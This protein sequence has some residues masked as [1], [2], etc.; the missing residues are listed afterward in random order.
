MAVAVI[1]LIIY[2]FRQGGSLMT[3]SH[4]CEDAVPG[5]EQPRFFAVCRNCRRC[6][7]ANLIRSSGFTLVELLVVVAIIAALSAIALPA[8]SKYVQTSRLTIAISGIRN[9]DTAIRA[10]QSENSALPAVLADVVKEIPIDPWGKAY[11][12]RPVAALDSALQ[13]TGGSP[14]NTDYDLFSYGADGVSSL[15]SGNAGN[16][17]DV[18]RAGNG[19]FY[20]LRP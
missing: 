20:G 10:Y 11:I 16:L 14:L 3:S 5:S 15:A 12:Y 17:D 1:R 19:N 4:R 8:Y 9:T 13:S 18:V 7:G 6:S 2:C